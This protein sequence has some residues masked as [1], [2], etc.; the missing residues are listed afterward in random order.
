MKLSPL[1]PALFLQSI[2]LPLHISSQSWEILFGDPLLNQVY[3]PIVYPAP[4]N[5]VRLALADDSGPVT[6]T[7]IF[8]FDEFGNYTGQ[9]SIGWTTDWNLTNV[10]HTGASYWTTF[11]KLRK[12]TAN[13]QIAWTYNPPVTA[14]IFWEKPAPNGSVCLQYYAASMGYVIDYVNANGQLV[15]RFQFSGNWPESYLPGHDNSLIYTDDEW[16]PSQIH[17]VKLDQNAQVVWELD[18]DENIYFMSGSLPDGSTYYINEDNETLTKLTEEGTVAWTRSFTEYFPGATYTYFLDRLVRQDGSIILCIGVYDFSATNKYA[19]YFINLNPS[20]GDPIWLKHTATPMDNITLFSGPMVEMPDGGILAC[21]GPVIANIPDNDQI[22]I[23]RTDPNGNTLTNQIAGTI[24]WDENSDCTPQPGE[25]ALKQISVIAQSGTKKYSATTDGNGNF[26]MVTTGG[27]YTLSIVQPGSY[28]SYCG[29]SNTVSLGIS[30]DTAWVS[31]GAKAA[32]VCPEMQVSIGSPVFRRCFDNNY[33]T[34]QFQNFGTAP[35]VDAYVTVTLDP[36]LIYLSATAPLLSQNGQTFTFD[37]GTVDVSESGFFT[38]NIKVDCD[39][40]LGELLCVDSHVYPDT[41]CIETITK[42]SSNRFCLPV[43]AS[44]DPNDK[45][46][47]VEGNPETAKI[48]P[49]LGLEYLIR[50][51]NTGTDTSFNIVIA[52]TLSHHLDPTSVV[53]GA[54]SHPYFFELRDGNILR[55]VFNN[56]LLPDSNTNEPASHGFVKFFIR[57]KAG[58]PIGSTLGNRAAIFFDYND[59]VITNES[60]LVVT[61]SSV[62]TKVTSASLQAKVRPVPAHD[63]VEVLLPAAPAAIVSWKLIDINGQVLR[64]GGEEPFNF[65]I[66]R[67]GLPGGVYWCQLQLENGA[68]AIGRLVFD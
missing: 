19:L 66:R 16:G 57:Q 44:Y 26:S 51:Q 50:F 36:K 60:K 15:K 47:F 3:S 59:P 32:I 65:P 63:K 55:F 53:P 27:D 48:L 34:V 7:S 56:I 13:N 25:K 5:G 10:D 67:N 1:L 38:I 6:T 28:W 42:M 35:A 9:N 29:F 61:P 14:G 40:E 20:N 58:N 12:L 30:N 24:Y 43:V 45:T 41:L 46:A 8:S 17:W 37:I 33:L 21:F 2:F 54:S 11:Y 64:T 62:G 18:L 22:L 23:V 52:D 31:I 39:S 68:I 49:D 4:N